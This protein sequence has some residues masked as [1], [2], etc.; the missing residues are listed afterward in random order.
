[1]NRDDYMSGAVDHQTFYCA[2][3]DAIG[4]AA[5]ER[6]VLMVA[7]LDAIKRALATDKNLN[8]IPLAKWDGMDGYIRGA[9]RANG[10]A[11]MAVSWSGQPLKPNTVCWSLSESVCVLKAAARRMV[12]E[13]R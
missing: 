7:N 5:V 12:E 13:S 4:R 3:A 9:V 2:V 6:A 1:M 8:N 10:P 11:V